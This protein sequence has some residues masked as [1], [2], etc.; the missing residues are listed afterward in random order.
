[1]KIEMMDTITQSAKQH[2]D[3][4]EVETMETDKKFAAQRATQRADVVQS[5]TLPQHGDNQQQHYSHEHH[6]PQ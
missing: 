4:I 1:M 3:V 5:N 6:W 2:A